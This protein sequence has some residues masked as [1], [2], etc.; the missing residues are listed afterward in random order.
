MRPIQT[1]TAA[2]PVCE[3]LCLAAQQARLAGAKGCGACLQV[4]AMQQQVGRDQSPEEP[5]A[6]AA[7]LQHLQVGRRSD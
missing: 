5:A 7:K 2:S 1:C 6:A 3:H 4:A